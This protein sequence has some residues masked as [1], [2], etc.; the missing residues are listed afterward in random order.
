MGEIVSS[1]PHI[2]VM[3]KRLFLVSVIA[4]AAC[5]SSKGADNPDAARWEQQTKNVTITRDDWGIAHIHGKTDAD[6]VFGLVYAQAED[7]FNRVEMNFVNAMGRLAE[8]AGEREIYRDLRMKLFIDPDSIKAMYATSPES[9]KVLMTAWAD[10]LNFYLYKHPNVTPKVIKK[11][12]PWMALTFSEGSI[13]GD[14]ERVSLRDLE[15]F[16]GGKSDTTKALTELDNN[17]TTEP[18]GS[19]GIAIGPSI[20]A[21]NTPSRSSKT[22]TRHSISM[23]RSF[24]RSCRRRSSCPTSPARRWRRRSS[25]SIARIT[26]RSSATPT[27]NG[28]P[29]A[30]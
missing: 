17:I 13:G 12:E 8:T 1:T 16:Y 29:F 23:G 6:A 11:F 22:V 7:D 27:A 26:G 4:A 9:L 18:T 24:V 30:S 2:A 14:I 19:N 28:S 20:T 25:R 3:K 5:T 10:G 15:K 21:T